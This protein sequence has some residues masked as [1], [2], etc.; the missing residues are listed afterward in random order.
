MRIFAVDFETYYDNECSIK[1]LGWKGYFNHYAFDAY[2]VTVYAKDDEGEFCFAGSPKDLDWSILDGNMAISHNASFDELLYHEGLAKG[3][4]KGPEFVEWNCTAD[5]ASFLGIPRALKNASKEVLGI[6]VSKEVRDNMKGQNWESMT[7]EFQKQVSEYAIK[8]SVLCLDLWNAVSDKWPDTER[9]ISQINRMILRNGIPMDVNELKT[10]KDFLKAE[11]FKVEQQIPWSDDAPI[12]SPKAF[13]NACRE[14]GI[15]PPKSLAMGDPD[16]EEWIRRYGKKFLWVEAV[17]NWRRINALQKKL[18]SIYHSTNAV[19]RCYIGL[20]YFGAHTGRFSGSGGNFNVQNLP[21]AE[22]FGVN[23]RSLITAPAGKS[24]I[25]V[26]LSQI[27]VRTLAW[28]AGDQDL[29]AEIAQSDDIYEVFAIR[30][31]MWSKDRGSLRAE[32]PKLR[33]K[34][35]TIVLGCGYGAGAKKF[36]EI[37]DMDMVEAFEAVHL[38]RRA[39]PKVP[40]LW[41]RYDSCLYSA[42]QTVSSGRK[43]DLTLPSGRSLNYSGISF[44]SH[45]GGRQCVIDKI[46][47]GNKRKTRVWGG[48]ITENA[49]QALA[50]DIF[51]HHIVAL[52]EAGHKILFH[53]HDEVVIEAPSEGAEETLKEVVKIMSTA[54]EWIDLPL[55]AEGK[56]LKQYEK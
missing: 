43:W 3:W 51:C 31:G 33:H 53:V 17:R 11:L 26:D 18:E 39:L 41:S 49:S 45:N 23:L 27:E 36:S 44:V 55:S 38:Y 37:S 35:K 7:P 16:A 9:R 15:E 10:Q 24:F 21:R 14:V 13:N 47:G 48:V 8:D 54:P 22:M 29:L 46:I 12:L 28:L 42:F 52:H 32:D 20:T 1:T 40:K 2:L 5:M 30:F 4:W 6:E 56:I 50:R 34:I 19:G 25:V